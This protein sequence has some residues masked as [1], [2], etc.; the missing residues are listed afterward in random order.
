MPTI[1]HEIVR[2]GKSFYLF[3]ST[4]K[5]TSTTPI[6]TKNINGV[7]NPSGENIDGPTR[8][9]LGCRLGR[10]DRKEASELL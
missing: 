7:F 3:T 1:S 5:I 9:K 10:A 8:T 2:K 6:A 4:I